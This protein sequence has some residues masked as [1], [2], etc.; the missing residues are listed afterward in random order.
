MNASE[1]AKAYVVKNKKGKIRVHNPKYTRPFNIFLLSFSVITLVLS[2]FVEY[3][4]IKILSRVKNVW[5]AVKLMAHIDFSEVDL[6]LPF[7]FETL[8]VTV[9]A[10]VYSAILGMIFAVFMARN[11]TPLK[12]FPPIFNAAFTLIRAIPNFIFVLLV[13]VCL[14]F[15]VTPAIIGLCISSTAIFARA[16]AHA[17]EELDEGTLEALAST[18]AGKLKVFFAAVLPSALTMLV[19]WLT[20]RFEGNFQGASNLGMV[21]AGGI[22][23]LISAAFGSYKYGRAWV[24][25]LLVV[26]FT[27]IFEISFNALKRR[28]KG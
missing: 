1:T 15:G 11:I 9:L 18:G 14:G 8:C 4:W 24:A 7:F 22:G 21:G 23:F 25:V 27:Y 5:G 16:F 12:I 20:M 2:Y 28:L 10:T 6:I 17:F 3:D 13:I 26:V 19:A